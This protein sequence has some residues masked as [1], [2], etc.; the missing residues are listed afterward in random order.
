MIAV[1]IFLVVK[2]VWYLYNTVRNLFLFWSDVND[3]NVG[4]ILSPE[5]FFYFFLVF[6]TEFRANI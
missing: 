5:S 2:V 1:N 3:K 6:K 4:E